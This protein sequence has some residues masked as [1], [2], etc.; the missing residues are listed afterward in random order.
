MITIHFIY[1]R[2]DNF[3]INLIIHTHRREV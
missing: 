3:L 2:Y 1:S